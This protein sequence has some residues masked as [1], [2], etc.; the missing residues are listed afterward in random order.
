MDGTEGMDDG[1]VQSLLLLAL[2]TG[3]GNGNGTGASNKVVGNWC[4]AYDGRI[5]ASDKK[6][7]LVFGI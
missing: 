4:L 7:A 5:R 2:G 6:L 3:T 1:Y